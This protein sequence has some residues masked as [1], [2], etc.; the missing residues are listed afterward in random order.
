[1]KHLLKSLVFS[2]ASSVLAA[3]AGAST[4]SFDFNTARAA[5]QS[6]FNRTGALGYFDS[7]LGTLTG[8]SFQ[9]TA[10]GQFDVTLNNIQIGQP[11][12]TYAASVSL[13]F[14]SSN[15]QLTGLLSAQTAVGLDFNFNTD[16]ASVVNGASGT[17][18]QTDSET[19]SL[20]VSSILASL[21]QAGGGSFDV[22]CA[23]P[24]SLVQSGGFSSGF[25]VAGQL[26]CGAR[27]EYTY[28]A[29]V[30]QP[31]NG[32]PEPSTLALMGLALGGLGLLRRKAANA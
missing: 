18:S 23:N 20:D 28:T 15:S 11:P 2:A 25:T 17:F 7:N 26:S 24:T 19:R 5:L 27:V 29:A 12:A 13:P 21:V 6:S 1:M 3:S 10:E 32:V 8:V 22:T 14:S 16:L 30:V 4:V 31:P 9:W